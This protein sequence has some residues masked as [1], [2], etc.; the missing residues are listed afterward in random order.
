M[1]DGGDFK[2]KES[3]FIKDGINVMT[4]DEVFAL[5]GEQMVIAKNWSKI[6]LLWNRN[7]NSLN[8]K[9]KQIEGQAIENE[10]LKKSN[11]LY[12]ENNHS[13]DKKINELN[14]ELKDTKQLLD[15][16]KTDNLKL[17]ND[18]N[19]LKQEIQKLTELPQRKKVKNG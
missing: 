10:A 11:S 18:N 5:L 12:I 7:Y 14:I 9:M 16:F 6:A 13:L 1:I 8:E 3:P 15:Q 19:T 4:T 2:E 17:Q